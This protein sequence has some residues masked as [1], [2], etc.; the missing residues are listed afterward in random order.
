M[1]RE[2]ALRIFLRCAIIKLMSTNKIAVSIII[3]GI[4]IALAI[5]LSSAFPLSSLLSKAPTPTVSPALSPTVEEEITETPTATTTTAPSTDPAGLRTAV[6]AKSGI[7]EADFEYSSSYNDGVIA[8]GSLKNKNDI[9][10]AGWFAAKVDDNWVVA[11]I[12]QGV[13][14]C[15]EI[16]A[17]DFPTSWISHC[18]N[19]SGETVAR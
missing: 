5:Y 7:P 16:Q 13:P 18:V 12:G 19:D 14:K 8:R 11:Y 9:S 4:I 6:L 3:A 2:T 17:Y 10:G 1:D 15:S